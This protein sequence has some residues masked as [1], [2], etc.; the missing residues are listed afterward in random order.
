MRE[1]IWYNDTWEKR[2]GKIEYENLEKNMA[3]STKTAMEMNEQVKTALEMMEYT[4]NNLFITGRAGTGKSTLLEYFRDTTKK[5]VVVLAPTGV[6]AINVHGQTIH[7]FF[8]FGINVRPDGI[9]R[10]RDKEGMFQ[11]IDTII[12]DEISM[13]RAD[14]LDCIDIFMKLH[15]KEPSLPFGGV[16][17]ICIGDLYQL[18]PVITHEEAPIFFEEYTSPYFFDSK[19]FSHMQCMRIELQTIYRQKDAE[20]IE[21]L[22]AVRQGNISEELLAKINSR[23]FQ[24]NSATL[25]DTYIYLTTTNAKADQINKQKLG[26]IRSTSFCYTGEIDGE[27]NEKELPVEKELQL[28]KGSQVMMLVNDQQGRWV[29]GTVCTI[30]TLRSD[31]IVIK[32][33]DGKK[34]KIDPYTWEKHRYFY[35]EATKKVSSEIVGEYTQYPLKLAWAMTIHKSQGK[36]FD[37]VI[38][39]LGRGAF[40]HGQVYV[41]LSRCRSLD[42][43]MLTTA[44][45]KADILIEERIHDFLG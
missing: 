44:I 21:L 14:L 11:K 27:F 39:D 16:Q 5:N 29:N 3:K 4:S 36:T 42:G 38:I 19:V 8:K 26:Q 10:R 7:S 13:V 12:I 33:A 34:H 2:F 32:M 15:G 37:Q 35:D 40:A 6:A 17:V 23:T 22:N 20:F 30:D 31:E 24:P 25:H 43:I 41:A 9:T 45:R 28:K 1:I 18:P